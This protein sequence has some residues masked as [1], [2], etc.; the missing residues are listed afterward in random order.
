MLSNPFFY[1]F[2]GSLLLNIFFF[3]LIINKQNIIEFM[4]LIHGIKDVLSVNMQTIVELTETIYSILETHFKP[5]NQKLVKFEIVNYILFRLLYDKIIDIPQ[6]YQTIYF[7]SYPLVF[8]KYISD[9]YSDFFEKEIMN[10][11]EIYIRL[12]RG[13]Q[14]S[15][16]ITCTNMVIL[17][18]T[19]VQQTAKI[20]DENK[21]GFSYDYFKHGKFFPDNPG[22]KLSAKIDTIF[23]NGTLNRTL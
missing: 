5:K 12:Y 11:N 10:R 16:I 15:D 20:K 4:R 8:K 9:P 18:L 6:K 21:I 2:I 19:I 7:Y 22:E 13:F 1:L 23:K 3:I 17:L 14:K